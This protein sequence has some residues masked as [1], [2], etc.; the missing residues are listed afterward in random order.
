MMGQGMR[1]VLSGGAVAMITVAVTVTLAEGVGLV[2]EV[3]YAIGY[4]VALA[5]HFSLQRWFVWAHHDGFA[6]SIRNQLA[7]YLPFALFNY[8][9]V[10]ASIALLPRLLGVSTSVAYLEAT[11][12]ITFLSFLVLRTRI[13]HADSVADEQA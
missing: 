1:Y 7:R 4:C 3:S 2:Y 10:A 13:F 9:F 11:A 12:I 6:L 8:G 5:T